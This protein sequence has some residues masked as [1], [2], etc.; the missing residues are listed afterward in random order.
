MAD[1]WQTVFDRGCAKVNS[2][3]LSVRPARVY[4][5]FALAVLFV[6][7]GLHLKRQPFDAH[8]FRQTQTLSTIELFYQ[9]GIDLLYP[10]VNY[11][12][13]PGYLVLEFPIFQAF[14]ALLYKFLGPNLIIVRVFN[15][16][17][18]AGNAFLTYLIARRLFNFEIAAA[19]ALFYIT[20]PLN[21]IFLSSSLF[22][23]SAILAGL[24]AVYAGIRISNGEKNATLWRIAFVFSS[25][26]AAVM[27]ALYLFPV[28]MF[29]SVA[30]LQKQDKIKE[31]ISRFLLLVPA[32]VCFLLW[33]YHSSRVNSLF[34]FTAGLKPSSLLGFSALLNSAWYVTIGKRLLWECVGPL[35]GPLAVAGWGWSFVRAIHSRSLRLEVWMVWSALCT[36]GYWIAFANIN[37]PH[38]YYSLVVLPYLSMAA[39][40]TISRL[41]A[42]AIGY[43]AK[44]VLQVVCLGLV[45]AVAATSWAYFSLR[46]GLV[47]EP[48]M[49]RF[50]GAVQG[51]VHPGDYG[52]I[53]ISR[54]LYPSN[55]GTDLASALYA[56][57]LRGSGKFVADEKEAINIWNE[58]R[59]HYK[60]LHYVIF[61]GLEPSQE[62]T[63]VFSKPVLLDRESQIF[64]FERAF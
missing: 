9:D 13:E 7:N 47:E 52:I 28:V 56:A 44:P 58:L 51:T 60:N 61:F 18:T 36:V 12:G 31:S 21:L 4:I 5:V 14:C 63:R 15:V 29:F 53:F 57:K 62:I 38:N 33:S 45:L 1:F 26:V 54:K 27:K 17:V 35:A 24:I 43:P 48:N 16:L 2:M 10:R 20:A 41:I 8:S 23:P 50:Q 64:V 32:G 3:N 49:L 39:A 6:S 11:C 42:G 25:C 46:R 30:V 19:A 37:V 34:Y 59:P 55:A 40:V 22:D